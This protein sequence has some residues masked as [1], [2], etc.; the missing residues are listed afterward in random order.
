MGGKDGCKGRP[1]LYLTFCI[2]QFW[3]GKLYFYQEKVREK[4]GN[5]ENSCLWQPWR[6][7]MD[8]FVIVRVMCFFSGGS[9]SFS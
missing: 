5:F 7:I 6:G 4:S 3:S 9:G 2:Y 1:L 8:I